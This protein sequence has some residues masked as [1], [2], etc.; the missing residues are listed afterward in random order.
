M[1]SALSLNLSRPVDFLSC[2]LFQ[3]EEVWRHAP[4]VID[5]AE[6][7]FGH[8]G[9]VHLEQDGQTYRIEKGT[10]MLLWP[11]LPHRGTEDSKGETSFYWMHFRLPLLHTSST[12]ETVPPQAIL[13]LPVFC[14][15]PEPERTAILFRQLLHTAYAEPVNTLACHY[16]A[17]L[18]LIELAEQ[19][20]AVRRQQSLQAITPDAHDSQQ[21]V[22][23]EILEWVRVHMAEQMTATAVAHKFG[24]NADYLTR[25]FKRRLGVGFVRYVNSVRLARAK[26][27]LCQTP[28]SIKEISWQ[29]GFPDEKY[30]M[31]LFRES[32]GV[33]PTA[34]RNA[35]HH[36][37]INNQ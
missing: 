12:S 34:Y 7:L 28:F 25:L 24:F 8:K 18:L 15:L 17:S 20:A 3:T 2:G 6:I 31:R 37:H 32:E 4:R 9:C 21:L 30:F 23:Q 36:T 10:A 26:T 27:L 29:C 16:Q 13:Q 1:A 5:S 19:S 22:F 11:G 35:Y 14:R 33:T